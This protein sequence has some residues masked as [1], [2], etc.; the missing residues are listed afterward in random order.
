ML[1]LL[2]FSQ[3]SS[4]FSSVANNH[5]HTEFKTVEKEPLL[6]NCFPIPSYASCDWVGG[7]TFWGGRKQRLLSRAL[8]R[9]LGLWIPGC[10]V[11]LVAFNATLSTAIVH[12]NPLEMALKCRLRFSGSG[13]WPEILHS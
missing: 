8:R 6:K 13:A 4:I 11:L 3:L 12:A 1:W 9:A 2:A 7:G 5:Y 10:Q